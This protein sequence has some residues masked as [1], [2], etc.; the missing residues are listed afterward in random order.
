[1]E[2]QV[3]REIL[4]GLRLKGAKVAEDPP[5]LLGSLRGSVRQ[6]PKQNN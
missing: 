6:C 2:V 1:M 5:R 4:C 3:D